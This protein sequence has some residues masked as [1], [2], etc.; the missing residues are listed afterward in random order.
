M[1]SSIAVIRFAFRFCDITSLKH[2]HAWFCDSIL[3]LEYFSQCTFFS[4]LVI[5]STSLFCLHADSPMI[6]QIPVRITSTKKHG[7]RKLSL[8]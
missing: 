3:Q 7:I 4:L 8:L 5:N 6:D 2:E 1:E